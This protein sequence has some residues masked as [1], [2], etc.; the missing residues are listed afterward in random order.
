MKVGSCHY[1]QHV[2]SAWIKWWSECVKYEV[3]LTDVPKYVIHR[4]IVIAILSN[5][6]D[7]PTQ[8]L[9]LALLTLLSCWSCWASRSTWSVITD[10]S[11]ASLSSRST[12]NQ[13][14]F[15]T[16]INKDL[17]PVRG[18]YPTH[19]IRLFISNQRGFLISNQSRR[20][21]SNPIREGINPSKEALYPTN[22]RELISNQSKGADERLS[23]S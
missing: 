17:Y 13:W 5:K 6:E 16:A 4:K 15:K 22:Q 10:V 7:N 18:L 23:K 21:E 12:Y 2:E 8:T 19:Q 9:T 20:V 14:R 3:T 11:F 1:C